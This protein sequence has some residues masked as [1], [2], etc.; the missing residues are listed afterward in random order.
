MLNR[1]T[2]IIQQ[3]QLEVARLSEQLAQQ[4]EHPINKI[5]RGEVIYPTK[6]RFK[7]ALLHKK[8]AIIAEIKRKSPSKGELANIADPT[9]LAQ[10]YIDG[11]ANALSI[12][13]DKTFFGG[14]I[15]DL[16]AVKKQLSLNCPPILRKDFII[17]PIQIAEAVAAGAEAILCIVAIHGTQTAHIIQQ[18]KKMGIDVLTEVHDRVELDVALAS[19]ADIIGINNRNLTTFEVN[20]DTAL[21]L[22]PFIPE[23]I[24]TVAESGITTPEH[25]L[26]YRNAGF[27][28]V[29]IGEALVKSPS[30]TEFIRACREN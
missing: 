14:N 10:K 12:L 6:G 11:E 27:N 21:L 1:L 17:D 4:L 8:L 13:T 2:P 5:L 26:C 22:K 7:K 23:H 16:I 30:P 20:P 3:K 18:A 19:G 15:E 28:A 24:I 25:A 9:L 29:L